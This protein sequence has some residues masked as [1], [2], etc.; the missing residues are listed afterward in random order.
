MPVVC[1]LLPEILVG[2]YEL[3]QIATI[4]AALLKA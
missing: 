4:A 3:K 1:E 2:P